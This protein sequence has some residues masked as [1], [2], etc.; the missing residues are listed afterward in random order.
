MGN[1]PSFRATR[2]RLQSFRNYRHAEVGFGEGVNLVVGP[3]GQGK[4]NLIEAVHLTTTGRLIRGRREAQAVM[5]GAECAVVGTQFEPYDQEVEANLPA[6]GRKTL[7]LNGS[8]LRRASDL[9]GKAPCVCF[10]SESLL[11]L[12]GEPEERRHFLDSESSQLHP[13]FVKVCADYKRALQQRNSLLRLWREEHVPEATFEPW[14]EQLAMHGETI[15]ARRTEWVASLEP[16]FRAAYHDLGGSEA[17][18]IRSQVKDDAGSAD[19][20]AHRLASSRSTDRERG[21]TGTGPHRDDLAVLIQEKDARDFASQGQKRTIVVALKLAVLELIAQQL[22]ARPILLLDDV[23]S[24]LD[25]HRRGSLVGLV[26]ERGGQV[27]VTCTEV[28]Q[29]GARIA[30]GAATFEVTSGTVVAR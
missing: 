6:S 19:Q 29:A 24:D 22:S 15:R 23:F 7:T 28:S 13:S 30:S 26:H 11:L 8:A 12:E 1:R 17:V 4:T 27:F 21:S 18:T 14:E 5:H 16:C 20:I 25:S 3:N 9:L 10:T 2:I